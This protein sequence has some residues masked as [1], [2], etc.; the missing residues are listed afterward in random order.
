MEKNI[1]KE[2]N[3]SLIALQSKFGT[4]ILA[5][6][7]A[8]IL[9]NS[10][11]F[12]ERQ[13][14]IL[15]KDQ[16]RRNYSADISELEVEADI[17]DTHPLQLSVEGYEFLL[18]LFTSRSS[19]LDNLPE[20]FYIHPF[21]EEE[22]NEYQKIAE[23]QKKRDQQKQILDAARRFFIPLDIAFNQVR[24]RR[25]LE[26][27]RLQERFDELLCQLWPHLDQ[28]NAAWGR[29]MC[30]LH[31]VSYVVGDRNK[32]KELIEFVLQ[33]PIKFK[34]HIQEAAELPEHMKSNMGELE[35]GYDFNVGNV[36]PCFIRV[37][38]VV[39]REL[40]P[41]E[42]M[43]YYDESSATGKLLIE[44]GKYYFPLDTDVQFDFIIQPDRERFSFGSNQEEENYAIL[45]FSSKI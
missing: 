34:E 39:I 36:I 7:F 10:G 33:K 44:L 23:R 3:S 8:G 17:L 32:T 42:F 6:C 15:P 28:K 1:E 41:L 2:I 26:E 14:H 4:D 13:V 16:F 45:G 12:S 18:K 22:E 27:I 31:L 35:L 25:E 43:E 20:T 9:I 21:E 24:V 30:S 5:E 29:F 11:K 40:S 19:T 38:T 37:V